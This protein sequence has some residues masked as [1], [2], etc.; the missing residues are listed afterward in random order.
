MKKIA[1]VLSHHYKTMFQVKETHW[2]GSFIKSSVVPNV[3][4]VNHENNMMY[5]P[6]SREFLAV[7]NIVNN[8]FFNICKAFSMKSWNY[9]YLHEGFSVASKFCP[10]SSL[11][12]SA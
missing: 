4:G 2:K 5:S 8:L 1:K 10:A 12:A 9:F 3:A 7:D 6:I 11:R